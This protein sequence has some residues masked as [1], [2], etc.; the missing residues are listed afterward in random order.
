MS[1][2]AFKKSMAV[3]GENARETISAA[4]EKVGPLYGQTRETVRDG[5]ETLNENLSEVL[6]RASDNKYVM[7]ATRRGGEVLDTVREK[8][9]DLPDPFKKHLAEPAK[10]A[11]KRHRLLTCL[12]IAAVV[13]AVFLAVRQILLPKDD[14]WTPHEPSG[15]FGDDDVTTDFSEAVAAEPETAVEEAA[16]APAE[17]ILSDT[18][19]DYGEDAYVGSNP[20]EGYTIKGNERSMKYHTPDGAGYSR[21]NADV[22]FVSSEAAEAAGF[23]KALR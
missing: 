1:K 9:D 10:P 23:T 3:A 15:A 12:G 14:G 16:E 22:W 11:R 20:P 2:K 5:L 8:A 6:E 18:E 17:P 7:E 19:K 4:A 21:T 13:G